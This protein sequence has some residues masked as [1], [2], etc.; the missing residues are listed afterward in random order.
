MSERKAI[1]RPFIGNDHEDVKPPLDLTNLVEGLKKVR[2]FVQNDYPEG[3]IF[4]DTFSHEVRTVK[5]LR[6]IKSKHPEL[7]DF[8]FQKAERGLW[9]HDIVEFGMA[10]DVTAISQSRSVDLTSEKEANEKIVA[11]RLLKDS[12]QKLFED[13]ERAGDAFKKNTGWENVSPEAMVDYLIDKTDSNMCFHY[14]VSQS[15]L[16]FPSDSLVYT[17]T[18]YENFISNLE[19]CPHKEIV[20]IAREILVNQIKFIVNL[21]K[22]VSVETRPKEIS[23]EIE[24]YLYIVQTSP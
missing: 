10:H 7:T 6:E 23:I 17:F 20:P 12:D 3:V 16:A 14:W 24:K 8:D 9:V 18:Q 22:N 13:I 4:D 1:L 2:R 21:W 19:V 11:G 15:S 5:M